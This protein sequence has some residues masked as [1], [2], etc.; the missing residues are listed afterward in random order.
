[1]GAVVIIPVRYASTRLP[2]KPILEVAREVTGKYIV[3]HVYEN[4]ARAS[5]VSRVI[6]ATDDERVKG[7]V[8]SFGGEVQMTSPDHQCGTDRIAEVA[9][10]IDASIVVNVQ[11]D[12][13]QVQPEQVQQVVRLLEE[14][15]TPVMGTLAYPIDSEDEW[16]DPNAVK[17]VTDRRGYALYFSRSPLPYVRDSEDWLGDTPVRPLHH[18]GIY[19][20][21]RDFLLEYTSTPACPL[22][23]AEKLEQLRAL[24]EGHRIKVGVT[25]SACIGIDTPEDLERWLE[26]YR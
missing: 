24:W 19:S 18:L 26:L 9:E 15:E 8:E 11:G 22:E 17:V 7:V 6:V 13:P 21:R 3:Q 2:G 12:E 20:Y 1:M 23:E 16:H 14:D 5:G 10:D 4:A 25:E